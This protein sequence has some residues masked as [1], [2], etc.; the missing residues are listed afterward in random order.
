MGGKFNFTTAFVFTFLGI[1]GFISLLVYVTTYDL[2]VSNDVAVLQ[3][4]YLSNNPDFIEA[5][6]FAKKGDTWL[7]Y[8][9][10]VGH[11]QDFWDVGKVEYDGHSTFINDPTIQ[12]I[13][14]QYRPSDDVEII[15]I[16]GD[17]EYTNDFDIDGDGKNDHVISKEVKWD[18]SK[19]KLNKEFRTV[20][21]SGKVVYDF[22]L[23]SFAETKL[24][25]EKIIEIEKNHPELL[26]DE[27]VDILLSY[28]IG[29][30]Y[31]FVDEEVDKK[32]SAIM[33]KLIRNSDL[34]IN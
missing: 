18:F 34:E 12:K 1:I 21:V 4:K 3:I 8:G 17:G 26:S 5:R 7:Y 15:E 6:M 28:V 13:A 25:I 27:E 20:S 2:T 30:S 9:N 19:P 16:L 22:I 10:P 23:P 14:I 11:G 29:K 32:V 31:G 33:L 24:S